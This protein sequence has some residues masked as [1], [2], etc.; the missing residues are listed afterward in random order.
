MEQ[1]H[2]CTIDLNKI[3]VEIVWQHDKGIYLNDFDSLRTLYIVYCP[4]CGVNL[5]R[6]SHAYFEKEMRE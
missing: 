2:K 3:G 1:L 5:L 4:F 6:A